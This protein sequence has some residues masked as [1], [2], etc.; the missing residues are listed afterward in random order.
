MYSV[1]M[2]IVG[3]VSALALYW[4]GFVMGWVISR[5][6]SP[7]PELPDTEE[8]RTQKHT[9]AALSAMLTYSPAVAYG[10]HAGG[11]TGGT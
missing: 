11:D 7:K 10:S 6:V 5:K 4:S 8:Q 3:A 2:G 9:Q 1:I